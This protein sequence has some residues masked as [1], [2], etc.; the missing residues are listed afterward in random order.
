MRHITFGFYPYTL[1]GFVKVKVTGRLDQVLVR[2][3]LETL[4]PDDWFIRGQGK[5]AYVWAPAPEA[6][7]TAVE[8][9]MNSKFK[10]LVLLM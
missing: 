4:R 10:C 1:G 7:E 6:T 2:P 9:I 5:G 8:L 3:Y